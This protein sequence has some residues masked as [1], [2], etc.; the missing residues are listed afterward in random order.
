M[1]ALP[2]LGLVAMMRNPALRSSSKL[3]Q[4]SAL[5]YGMCKVAPMET[6]TARR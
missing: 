6:R 5:A 2:G 4:V 1:S 3:G